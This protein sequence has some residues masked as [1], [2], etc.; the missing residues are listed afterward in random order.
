MGA[1]ISEDMLLETVKFL[2]YNFF[3]FAA[4]EHGLR[5][6]VHSIIEIYASKVRVAVTIVEA[7]LAKNKM[8]IRPGSSWTVKPLKKKKKNLIKRYLN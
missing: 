6:V 3:I 4:L 5:F 1:Y 7:I 8:K 2:Q